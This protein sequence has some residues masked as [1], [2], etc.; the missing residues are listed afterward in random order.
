LQ[1]TFEKFV[2]LSEMMVEEIILTMK[3]EGLRSPYDSVG[4]VVYFG[5]ML[6]KI[7]LHTAGKL[8]PDYV[9]NLGEKPGL[10]DTRC[11]HFLGVRYDALVTRTLAGGTDDEIFAWV[12][13]QGRKPTDEEIEIWNGFM[14]KRGWRDAGRERL[15]SRKKEAG[16]EQ[17]DE[18]QTMFDYIDADEGRPVRTFPS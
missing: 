6:D 2:S 1:L 10:F 9:E 14:T 4:G 15:N 17:R 5:R 11:L 12:L 7:R 8:P 13:T 16:F 3:I 18:I